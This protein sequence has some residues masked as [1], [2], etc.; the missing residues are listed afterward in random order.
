MYLVKK[1]SPVNNIESVQYMFFVEC[2]NNV[3][4]EPREE[5]EDNSVQLE[6]MNPFM[7]LNV[8]NQVICPLV[9][10]KRV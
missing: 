8:K 2:D 3:E 6:L 5:I 4:R 9:W 1:T 7:R 10:M